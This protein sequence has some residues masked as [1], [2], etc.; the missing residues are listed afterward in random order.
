MGLD[1]V[2]LV[3]KVEESFGITIPDAEAEKILTI[4][5]LYRYVLAKLDGPAL[6]ASGCLSAAAFY[7][8][9]R[10]LMGRFRVERRRIRPASPLDDLVPA[11]DRRQQWQ[12]LGEY[13]GWRLPELSRPGWVGFAF[14]GLFIP[15]ALTTIVAWGR[16]TGFA[17][18]ALIVFL[19][20]LLVGALLLAVAVYQVTRPF[21]TVLPAH[22][23]R[24][25]IP[26]ILSRN[27]GTFRINN[28]RG[29]TSIDVWDVLIAIIAEQVGVAPD[30]LNESTSFVNDLGLD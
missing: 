24:G 7:R 28:P 4:G 2:E 16:L 10:Q 11:T 5:D 12:R 25:L 19:F 13:L 9:R 22:D 20:G 21:A 17:P 18:D 1:T 30:Q 27:L 8:L 26:M 23:I 29:W 15:W 3:M 14:L 6:P